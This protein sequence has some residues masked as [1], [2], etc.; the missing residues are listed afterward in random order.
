[1]R[2]TQ[3]FALNR[4]ALSLKQPANRERFLRGEQ[5]YLSAYDLTAECRQLVRN[6]DWS[7]LLQAGGQIQALLK[8]A[9]T[10]GQTLYHIGAHNCGIA[11]DEMR[12]ACPRHVSGIGRLDTRYRFESDLPAYKA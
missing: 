10:V 6:R 9:A 12:A 3:G 8:L 1:M 7:G 11:V 5:T 4:F 2:S